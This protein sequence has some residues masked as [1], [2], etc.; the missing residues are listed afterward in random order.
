MLHSWYHML[1]LVLFIDHLMSQRVVSQVFSF[2]IFH[3]NM[4]RLLTKTEQG[5]R[6]ILSF[7]F[8]NS[9]YTE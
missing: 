3:M 7:P 6:Q 2:F 5:L 8:Y 9:A 1:S 4:F